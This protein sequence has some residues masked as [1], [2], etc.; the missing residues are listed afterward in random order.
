MRLLPLN[1]FICWLYKWNGHNIPGREGFCHIGPKFCNYVGIVDAELECT[2]NDA[3]AIRLI[4]NR[5]VGC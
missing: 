5:Y 2:T 1:E 3:H 4:L